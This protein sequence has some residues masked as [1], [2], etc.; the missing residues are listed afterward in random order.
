M[1]KDG[2]IAR[3]REKKNKNRNKAGIFKI[4]ENF[5][6]KHLSMNLKYN[7]KKVKEKNTK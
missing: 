1:Q 5:Q 2:N 6:L 7:K 3:E 4:A